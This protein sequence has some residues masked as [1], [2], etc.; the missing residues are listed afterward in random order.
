[1]TAYARNPQTIPDDSVGGSSVREGVAEQNNVAINDLFTAL[2]AHAN[3]EDGRSHVEIDEALDAVGDVSA[4][5]T[6]A[7]TAQAAAEAARDKSQEWADN[8]EDVAVETG[9]YSAKHHAIKA[10]ASAQSAQDAAD[11]I[12]DLSTVLKD[13]DIGTADGDVI[14]VQTGGKLPALSAED[15]TSVPGNVITTKGDIAYG[16]TGGVPTRLAAPVDDTKVLGTSGGVPAWVDKGDGVV[17]LVSSPTPAT[18][19]WTIPDLTIGKPLFIGVSG[20]NPQMVF[21]VTSG[22]SFGGGAFWTISSQSS[23]DSQD[24]SNVAILIPTA[25]TVSLNVTGVTGV[26]AVYAYQ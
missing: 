6:A 19:T 22:S 15:L 14:A 24:T 1:M 18:G 5:A 3:N 8:P 17:S 23:G 4:A 13:S 16:E 2:N 26:S 12:P 20:T 7:Q 21:S 9:A 25:T 11:A 10:A